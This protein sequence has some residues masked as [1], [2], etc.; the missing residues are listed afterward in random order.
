MSQDKKD[1]KCVQDVVQDACDVMSSTL[2]GAKKL[3]SGATDSVKQHVE[4]LMKCMNFV[5]K[6]DFDDL[7]ARVKY[8]ED[9][10]AE[11]ARRRAEAAAR[12]TGE[13]GGSFGGD[14]R[15]SSSRPSSGGFGGDRRDS[16]DSRPSGG[17]FGGDRRDSRPS[18]GGF[19]G[20]RRSGG[21]R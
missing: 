12:R 15:S 16:R 17:G 6:Q 14:R 5:K 13:R 7:V 4:E 18:S 2:E 10:H 20:G 3:T 11:A 1:N 19:G 8:L 9:E 21:D